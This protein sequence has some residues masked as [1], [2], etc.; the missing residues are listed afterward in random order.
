VIPNSKIRG[1]I[2]DDGPDVGMYTSIAVGPDGTVMVTYFDRGLPETPNANLKFASRDAMGNWTTHIVDQGTG[3]LTPTSGTVT[4]MYTSL[5]LR[6]DDG[7]PGVAYLAHVVDANGERAEVRYAES[8]V[9]VPTSANDWHFWVVDTGM[10]P[11]QDPNN[12]DPYPLPEGLGLFIDSTR[13]PTNQAPVVAYYDRQNG[14]LKVSKFNTTSGQFDVAKVLDGTTVDAGWSPT[15]AVDAQGVVHVAY[16]NAT[17][18]DLDYITDDAGAMREIVDDG[19]RIVGQS[20]DGLPKPEFH[21]V[22][23]DAGIVL[24]PDGQPLVV[25]QDATTQELLLAKRQ[26]NGMW[27]H[28]SIAG[29]TDPWPGAYGFF[30]A[31]ALLPS[32][33][34][35]STWVIDQPTGENWVE[36]FTRP[37]TFQ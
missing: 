12:P 17:T 1:G 27:T 16:V 13:N 19:Y 35:M 37:T 25:Y 2:A 33:V 10:V 8:Q 7:R 21:F 11:A 6:T 14:D 23:D 36:V 28:I 3:Q 20:P 15:V 30:A 9:A 31:D 34:V 24:P 29:A 5:S 22:G 26:P 4:G 18:D 32:E